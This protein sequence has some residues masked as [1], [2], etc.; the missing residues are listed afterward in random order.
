[1]R[2]TYSHKSLKKLNQVS[3]NLSIQIVSKNFKTLR[4]QLIGGKHD[5]TI[6][7]QT[8]EDELI[9]TI[10][11][12]FEDAAAKDLK[13]EKEIITHFKF[14][15]NMLRFRAIKENQVEMAAFNPSREEPEEFDNE[16]KN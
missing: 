13:T 4:E 3:N 16:L 7:Y 5:L 9:Q 1:M 2:D 15:F 11:F 12:V 10:I 14:R 6:G 8:L